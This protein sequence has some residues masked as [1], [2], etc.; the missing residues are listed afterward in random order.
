MGTHSGEPSV[1]LV[2]PTWGRLKCVAAGGVP[3]RESLRRAG[4]VPL[5][6]VHRCIW[7]GSIFGD[8]DA[9]SVGL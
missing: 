8:T 5:R 1:V 9:A 3:K 2:L 7:E 6:M 4:Q